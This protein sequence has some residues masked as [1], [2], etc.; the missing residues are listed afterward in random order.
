MGVFSF[1]E[2]SG[3]VDQSTSRFAPGGKAVYPSHQVVRQ[4]FP[5]AEGFKRLVPVLGPDSGDFQISRPDPVKLEF[6]VEDDSEEP[7]PPDCRIKE[8]AVLLGGAVEQAP[9]GGKEVKGAHV[10]S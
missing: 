5:F 4:G 10:F 3:A 8:F 6:N 9:L 2:V 1:C 7:E